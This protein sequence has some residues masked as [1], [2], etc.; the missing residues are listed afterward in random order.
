M[1][2]LVLNYLAHSAGRI[3][4]FCLAA[5][6][7]AQAIKLCFTKTSLPLALSP[8]GYKIQPPDFLTATRKFMVWAGGEVCAEQDFWSTGKSTGAKNWWRHEG[9]NFDTAF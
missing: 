1:R 9:A 4:R 7:Q 5:S 3:L 6:F 8:I 2:E